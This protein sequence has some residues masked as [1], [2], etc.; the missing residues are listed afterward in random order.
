M[1]LDL[2]PSQ[3]TP[4]ERRGE[5]AAILAVGLRRLR[6]RAALAP[7]PFFSENPSKTRENGLESRADTSVNVHAG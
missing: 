4:D 7:A 1:R 5:V 3:M 6:D 2:E